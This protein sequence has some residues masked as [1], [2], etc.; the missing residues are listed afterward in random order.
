MSESSAQ[1]KSGVARLFQHWVVGLNSI[2]T[3]WI[4]LLMLLINADV[5]SRLLFNA[6]IDGVSE[7]VALSIVGIVF[8]QLGDTVRANRLT[9]S[10]GFFN[11]VVERHPKLGLVL[12]I[13]YELCG[14]AFFTAI[15]FG[16]IP[17]FIQAYQGGYYAGTEGIFTVPIWPIKLSIVVGS[18]TVLAVF[19]ARIKNHICA[20]SQCGYKK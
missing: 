13:F 12:N 18:I 1:K 16:A 7:L 19:L 15:L 3:A 5:F 10:D 6:P 14:I 9:R 11:R 8:L 17:Y 20:F 4:F 2:G